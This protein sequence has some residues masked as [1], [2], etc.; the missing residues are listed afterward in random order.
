M[1]DQLN[2]SKLNGLVPAI[3]QDA[4]TRQVLMVG[5]MNREA[6]ERTIRDNRV[7]FWSRTKQRFW[8]KG[9]T[10]GNFLDVVSLQADC[11]NDS[12]LVLVHPHGPVCHTGTFTCFGE[13]ELSS[14]R[15]VLMEL[16]SVIAGRKLSMPEG[17]Y[18][19]KL[20]KAG[21]PRIAQ[22]VGEEGVEVALAGALQQKDRVA[23]ESGDL[24]YHLLVL[25]QES[26][27]SFYDV[28][29]VLEARRK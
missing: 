25:L 14:A 21:M 8:Q 2:F 20:F 7:T 17:S 4:T 13:S 3:I 18:T 5:F 15:D 23:E 22:K 28:L 29:R 9:E 19:T 16:E 10:S 27:V 1:I 12:L 11:D 24:L 26:G 6:V